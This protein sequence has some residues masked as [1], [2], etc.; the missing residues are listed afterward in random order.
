MP[1]H[2][3]QQIED[4]DDGD[5]DS[6]ASHNSNT[7]LI[8]CMFSHQALFKSE[9]NLFDLGSRNRLTDVVVGATP[10]ED[11]A[12]AAYSFLF[13]AKPLPSPTPPPLPYPALWAAFP[14]CILPTPPGH[15][16]A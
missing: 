3:R 1:K 6:A 2:L 4:D 12:S 7:A 8:F 14:L 15:R 16:I 11:I 10:L 13:T 9:F 5:F